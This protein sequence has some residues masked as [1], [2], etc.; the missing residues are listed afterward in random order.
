MIGYEN[1]VCPTTDSMYSV[2]VF[3]GKF[4]FTMF[5]IKQFADFLVKS[6]ANRR[7]EGK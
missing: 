3:G 1:I 4:L 7:E 2:N 5:C 6:F